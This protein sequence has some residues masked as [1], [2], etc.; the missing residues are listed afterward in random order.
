MPTPT[1]YQNPRLGSRFKIE[2]DG[3]PAWLVRKVQLPNLKL[4]VAEHASGG[5][6][7]NVGTA[8]A[9]SYSELTLEKIMPQ[10]EADTWAYDWLRSCIDPATGIAGLP[11]DYKKNLVIHHINGQDEVIETF[12]FDGGFP[13]AIDYGA[14]DA[15]NKD[16]LILESVTFRVDRRIR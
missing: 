7:Y 10:D 11:K 5:Q 1:Q 3:C 2:V 14:N 12:E 6:H 13:I 16:D 4:G 15:L 9:V 8:T